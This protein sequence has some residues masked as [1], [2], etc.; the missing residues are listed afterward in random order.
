M[1]MP[2]RAFTFHI[3]SEWELDFA[4]SRLRRETRFWKFTPAGLKS[5]LKV[6]GTT[7]AFGLVLGLPLLFLALNQNI[8]GLFE[9][10]AWK[11]FIFSLGIWFL[12]VL[13]LTVLC[14]WPLLNALRARLT[15]TCLPGEIRFGSR[16][17]SPTEDVQLRFHIGYAPRPVGQVGLLLGTFSITAAGKSMLHLDSGELGIHRLQE[18]AERFSAASA[19]PLTRTGEKQNEPV[20][21]E[22]RQVLWQ[23]TADAEYPFAATVEGESWRLRPGD[24]PAEALYTLVVDGTDTATFNDWPPAWKKTEAASDLPRYY[25]VNDRPVKFVS[26]PDGGLDILALHMR[27]GEFEREMNYLTKV[28]DPFADVDAVS[29]VEFDARVAE[30]RSELRKS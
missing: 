25:F 4:T 7:S 20:A 5:F 8:T 28:T 9:I 3:L 29:E 22:L 17:L 19:F 21:P 24:F 13:L 26:T 2:E 10:A 18:F 23:K 14:A 27:T 12:A 11:Q 16:C 30:V 6:Y 15:I 1:T